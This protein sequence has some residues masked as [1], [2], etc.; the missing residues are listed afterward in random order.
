MRIP[1]TNIPDEKEIIC[2]PRMI[3]SVSLP[4]RRLDVSTYER[5]NGHYTLCIHAPQS[6]GLPYGSIPRIFLAWVTTEV[7]MTKER[8]LELGDSMAQYLN[9]IGLSSRGGVRGDIT[10]FKDQIKRITTSTF[11]V[12]RDEEGEWEAN[13]IMPFRKTRMWWNPIAPDEPISWHTKLELTEEF[14]EEV[15]AHHVP[16]DR[17]TLLMLTHSPMSMDIYVWLTYRY[18]YLFRT[19]DVPWADIRNQF[20]SSMAD[21]MNGRK[22]FKRRFKEAAERVSELYPEARYEFTKDGMRLIPSRTHIPMIAK[23]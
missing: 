11:T 17:N 7:A 16:I 6:I 20:G 10:R 13:N 21:D 1:G 22:N 4:H 2:M 8:S 19:T 5:R 18:S 12:I 14:Y 9:L 15:L 3:S 23:R